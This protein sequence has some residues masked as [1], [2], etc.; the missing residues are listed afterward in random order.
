MSI[1]TLSQIFTA[2][3]MI[4][5]STILHIYKKKY[6]QLYCEYTKTEIPVYVNGKMKYQC[7]YLKYCF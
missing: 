6:Q 2:G 5:R 1:K 7:R 4:R 3:I